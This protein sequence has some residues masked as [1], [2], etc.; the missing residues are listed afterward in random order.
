MDKEKLR[1][2]LEDLHEELRQTP[3]V[4]K[5]GREILQHLSSDVQDLLG[6]LEEGG[7]ERR[8]HAINA[9]LREA[10]GHFE[11]SHPDFSAT[12]GRVLDTLAGMGF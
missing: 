1:K 7:H 2:I 3:D 9:R 4:D 8:T 5:K 6:S 10:V 11:V 12:L